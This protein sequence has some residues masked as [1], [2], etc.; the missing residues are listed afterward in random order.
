MLDAFPPKLLPLAEGGD[1]LAMLY[2]GFL[3]ANGHGGDRDMDG[4]VAW[5]RRAALAGEA[6]AQFNLA[7]AYRRKA[8]PPPAGESELFWLERSAAQGCRRR[9]RASVTPA[10]RGGG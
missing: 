3:K 1:P 5:Y 6:G 2:L 7:G 9:S 10:R 8:P 4:A